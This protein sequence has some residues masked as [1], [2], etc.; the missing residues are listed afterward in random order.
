MADRYQVEAVQ[1]AVEDAV[2]GPL[3][4]ESCCRVLACD[5]NG[6][7]QVERASRELALREFDKFAMAEGFMEAGEKAL[8]LLLDDD[9]LVT[10]REA[11]VFEAVVLWMNGGEPQREGR[12]GGV[13]LLRKVWIPF[14]DG[15]YLADLSSE[16]IVEDMGLDGLLLDAGML[17]GDPH[18]NWGGCCPAGLRLRSLD[19]RVLVPGGTVRWGECGVGGERLLAA[20]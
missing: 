18:E 8:G 11:R 20:G 4:V 9:G 15:E 13:G 6:L 5:C 17:K 7:M 16:P 12:C 1:G 3:T 10:E 14:I 19:T 2:V